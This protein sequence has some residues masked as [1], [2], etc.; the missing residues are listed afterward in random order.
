MSPCSTAPSLDSHEICLHASQIKPSFL[1][2]SLGFLFFF[3]F[4]SV[5]KTCLLLHIVPVEASEP[6]AGA[7]FFHHLWDSFKWQMRWTRE[8]YDAQVGLG[9]RRNVLENRRGESGLCLS[10]P[11]R[12]TVNACESKKVNPKEQSNGHLTPQKGQTQKITSLIILDTMR[13]SS[14]LKVWS[15]Q[16][17]LSHKGECS[18]C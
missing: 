7:T 10:N 13:K 17:N 1:F 8:A 9:C 2:V 18:D 15:M 5:F 6:Q 4:S 16:I 14:H 11:V 3:L 12:M